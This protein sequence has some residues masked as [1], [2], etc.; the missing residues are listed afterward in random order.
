M[1]VHQ[2]GK[3]CLLSRFDADALT[4][5]GIE[6]RCSEHTHCKRAVADLMCREGQIERLPIPGK[7]RF[8]WG[9][10]RTIRVVQARF[11]SVLGAPTMPV[12]QLVS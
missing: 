4:A 2:G 7:Q 6:P 5:D 12:S 3:V 9:R 8:V 11:S 10:G 1:G